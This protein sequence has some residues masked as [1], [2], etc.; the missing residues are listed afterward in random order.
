M[1]TLVAASKNEPWKGTSEEPE[2]VGVSEK[3][4]KVRKK[5]KNKLEQQFSNWESKST[6]GT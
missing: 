4:G 3:V 1:A 6:N 5:E 2:P